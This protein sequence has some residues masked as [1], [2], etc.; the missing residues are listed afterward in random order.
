VAVVHSMD[1]D[2][3]SWNLMIFAILSEVTAL[4]WCAEALLCALSRL[5][6]ALRAL[7]FRSP[8]DAARP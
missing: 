5:M 6:P 8:A 4:A 2:R 1:I 7:N 3:Y